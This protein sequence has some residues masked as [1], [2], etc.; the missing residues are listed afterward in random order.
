M[1]ECSDTGM[2]LQIQSFS[3][4]DG[5]GLR[6][7]IFLPGC[8]LR[9][10]WCSNPETWTTGKKI[11]CY[12]SKCSSCGTCETACPQKLRPSL[13]AGKTEQ[14]CTLCAS[15]LTA[16]PHRALAQFCREVQADEVVKK[17][18]REEV[19]FRHSGGGVTFSGGEATVQHAF[20]RCLAR[21]FHDYGVHMSIE[22][23]GMFEW[24]R[25][26]DIFSL[27]DHAF[28]DLKCMD[29]ALHKRLTG[30]DNTTILQNVERVHR[31]GLPITI[32]IPCIPGVNLTR[33]NLEAT[34]NFMRSRLPGA[35][36]EL[37]PYHNLGRE[38]YIALNMAK[39]L[40]EFEVP[41]PEEMDAAADF[42][43]SQGIELVSY[44]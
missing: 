24:E 18:M 16:C 42:M 41:N 11:V 38:K 30:Q 15:C 8:P 32:R 5:E 25:V 37:L 36:L 13:Q 2:L 1:L 28:M 33:E 44:R 3:V 7:A 34:A 4:R 43:R 19:F 29:P 12:S 35:N 39:Y 23:C 20:L 21:S 14:G 22:S 10:Q 31:Q 6:T 9:C 26:K 17:V 40:R 27:L